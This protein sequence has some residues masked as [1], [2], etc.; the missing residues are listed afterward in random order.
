M[1]A[2]AL[3]ELLQ[4]LDARAYDFVVPTPSTCRRMA[5]RPMSGPASLRDVFGWSRPF[6]LADLEPVMQDALKRSG[7]LLEGPEGWRSAVRVSRVHGRLFLHSAFPATASDAVFLG[8]DSYRFADLIAAELSTS[9]KVE[10]L[11]DV[12]AGAGVGGLVAQRYAPGAKVHL[13]D[14]NPKALALARINAAH[15]GVEAAVHEA[16]GLDHAPQ[17][18]DLILANPP[19]VAGA[20]GR[21]YKDGGDMHGA[22]LSLDWAIAGMHRLAPGGRFILYTGSAILDG[23]VDAFQHALAAAVDAAGLDLRY[24][25]LDPDIFSGELRREA[26]VD[27][28]RIAAVG[29]VITRPG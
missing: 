3:A 19:Y 23:G 7:V 27:V 24:R 28:E 1:N 10:T 14:V 22:R 17:A 2:D 29:A 4:M 12:G 9:A 21:T 5:Q 8:P 16:A 15:A 13:S 20:S 11:L 18:L 26:Y 6:D 25:E